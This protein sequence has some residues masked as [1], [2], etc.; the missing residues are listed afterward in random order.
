[1]YALVTVREE[2]ALPELREELSHRLDE[3]TG[4]SGIML[5]S[6]N[7]MTGQNSDRIKA[8]FKSSACFAEVTV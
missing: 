8:L 2:D 3:T 4:S 7:S 6:L 1:M 5:T